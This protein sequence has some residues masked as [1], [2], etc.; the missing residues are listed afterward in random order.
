MIWKVVVVASLAY[1]LGS[2]PFGYLV[3]RL[4]HGGDI[5]TTGSGNIGATNV[6]R[7]TGI[8][9]GV[10]TFVLDSAK[11]YLAVWLSATLI[12]NAPVWISLAAVAVILGHILPVFLKFRGGKGVATSFGAFLAIS[13]S[14]VLIVL[15]IFLI[16]VTIWHYVSLASIVAAAAFPLA[17]LMVGGL[18]TYEVG[19]GFLGAALVII[20]HRSNIY[21]L[22]KGTENRINAKGTA[23]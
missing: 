17:M 10:A 13:A 12:G 3:Y 1:L 5:R 7:T 15:V 18:S 22:L 20:R 21:R 11:G 2:I 23:R 8:T 14:S 19:A 9:A 6:L 16:V 4:R